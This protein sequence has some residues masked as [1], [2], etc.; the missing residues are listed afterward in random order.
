MTQ[1]EL[2]IYES[3][4]YDDFLLKSLLSI[5]PAAVNDFNDDAQ[6]EKISIE[7]PDDIIS[8]MGIYSFG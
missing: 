3:V 8:A 5:T 6:N 1:L 2:S 7:I 4:E